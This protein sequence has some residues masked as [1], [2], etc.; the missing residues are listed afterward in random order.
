MHNTW[1]LLNAKSLA[2][3]G[4]RD[5]VEIPREY[6]MV[7]VGGGQ[8]RFVWTDKSESS[9]IAPQDGEADSRPPTTCLGGDGPLR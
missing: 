7:M 6:V 9:L 2:T 3:A 5:K 8:G 1:T 4:G